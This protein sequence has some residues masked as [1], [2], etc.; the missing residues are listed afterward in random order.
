M[1]GKVVEE[2]E[3]IEEV[4]LLENYQAEESLTMDGGILPEADIIST[5]KQP[6]SS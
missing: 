2:V 4:L 3:E 6:T 1:S 5:P